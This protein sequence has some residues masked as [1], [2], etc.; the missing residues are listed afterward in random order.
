METKVDNVTTLSR[1]DRIWVCTECN[2]EFRIAPTQCSCGAT[3]KVFVEKDAVIE[4]TGR[5]TYKVLQNII[6]EAK[7]ISKGNIVSL[8]VKDRCTKNLLARKL[9]EEIKEGS[10]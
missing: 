9:I 8:I 2:K 7:Q 10:K 6:Y 1:K 5:K 3:D 4:D